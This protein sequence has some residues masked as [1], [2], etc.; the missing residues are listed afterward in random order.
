MFRCPFGWIALGLSRARRHPATSEHVNSPTLVRRGLRGPCC[1]GGR[2]STPAPRQS[3]QHR[4][5]FAAGSPGLARAPLLLRWLLM[6]GTLEC[7]VR[8][9]QGTGKYRGE[10]ETGMYYGLECSS[11]LTLLRLCP[12]PLFSQVSQQARLPHAAL[13]LRQRGPAPP[14]VRRPPPIV[15]ASAAAPAGLGAVRHSRCAGWG[16]RAGCRLPAAAS[17]RGRSPR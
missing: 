5:R 6:S 13:G 11:A 2:S 14:H 7:A 4:A 17:W 16:Q 8:I 3:G 10:C 9:A 12:A 1:G 15:T